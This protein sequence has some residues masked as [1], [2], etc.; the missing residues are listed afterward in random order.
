MGPLL[1]CLPPMDAQDPAP[2]PESALLQ[3]APGIA[4]PLA[5]VAMT[6]VRAQGPGGQNVNKVATAIQLRFDIRASSLPEALKE[7]LLARRDQR[8]SREGVLIIK[9]QG[10]R[11]QEANRAEALERLR[12]LL[13]GATRVPKKRRPTRPTLASQKRRVEHKLRRGEI[14]AGR[15]RVEE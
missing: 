13:L 6:A 5:E 8:I 7:R 3:I 14:K 2:I 1:P 12:E 10:S 4:L 15:G 11:S 9:S